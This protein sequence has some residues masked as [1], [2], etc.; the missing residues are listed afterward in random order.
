MREEDIQSFWDKH[1]CGDMLVSGLQAHRGDY[2]AFFRSYDEFRYRLEDHIPACLDEVPW[3]G[4][5]VLEIGLGQGA[6]S[7]QLIN[8]GAIWSGLDLTPASVERVKARLTLKNLP[9]DRL[10]CGSALDIPYDSGS[11][12]Y[13]FSHGVLHHIPEIHRAQKEIHR[14]LRPGGRLVAMFYARWSLNYLLSISV[15]RRLGLLALVLLRADPGGIYSQHLA[16]A[17]AVGLF[18]YLKMRNFVHRN[19]DGPL[20]PY[21]KVYDGGRLREDFPDFVVRR[22]FKRF[23]YAPP[24]PVRALPLQRALG[25]H[26]WAHMDRR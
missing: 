25:W 7:E 13:V 12:D 26:L 16:N 19:T 15:A 23:M 3:R 20:N 21:S 10:V 8:R 2:E 18:E 9:H 5:R 11:F 1:P 17:R 24:L 6:D 22:T 14:V 4:K